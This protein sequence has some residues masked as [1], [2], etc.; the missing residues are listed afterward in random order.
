MATI[1][2]RQLAERVAKQTGQTQVITKDII[3]R[4]IDGILNELARGNRLE[5]RDFGVFETVTRR[6]RAARNPKTG[7]Q[8]FV[9]AKQAVSFKMGRRMKNAVASASSTTTVERG[10]RMSQGGKAAED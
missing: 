9:P 1:T 8:V 6:S 10:P 5:F 4:Y 2:K 3:Q 7:E